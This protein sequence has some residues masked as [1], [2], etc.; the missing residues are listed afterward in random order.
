MP[1]QQTKKRVITSKEFREFMESDQ[2]LSNPDAFYANILA[3]KR[4][5]NKLVRLSSKQE[6]NKL[7]DQADGLLEI[8]KES[9]NPVPNRLSPSNNNATRKVK[10][11]SLSNSSNDELLSILASPVQAPLKKPVAKAP[12]KVIPVPAKAPVKSVARTLKKRNSP[13]T[14]AA[15]NLVTPF[16]PPVVS[17]ASCSKLNQA[18]VDNWIAG[19]AGSLAVEIARYRRDPPRPTRKEII[20]P[21]FDRD[22]V[23]KQTEGDGT[24]LL[25]AFLTDMSP[26]YRSLPRTV[27]RMTGQA[28]RKQVYA[29][30]FPADVEM[31]L[32]QED[33]DNFAEPE[34]ST[35]ARE[36]VM[37][38]GNIEL[39]ANARAYIRD[40]DGY[41]YDTDVAHLQECFGVRILLITKSE[42]K[43][44]RIRL[45][46]DVN[47]ADL[48]REYA[49]EQSANIPADK[50]TKYILIF[51][52]PGHYEG[53][54]HRTR[55]QYIFG[56]PE[57][58]DVI[59]AAV[60]QEAAVDMDLKE[61][62]AP[63]TIVTLVDGRVATVHE[64]GVRG[65]FPPFEGA[66]YVPISVNLDV[67]ETAPYLADL[68]EIVSIGDMPFDSIPYVVQR[69]QPNVSVRLVN[70]AYRLVHRK[71]LQMVNHRPI[72]LWLKEG[73]G[74]QLYSLESI[75][76]V[77][78]EPAKGKVRAVQG[79]RFRIGQLKVM[80]SNSASSINSGSSNS[81]SSPFSSSS[82]SSSSSFS[83]SPSSSSSSSNSSSSSS[84]S[85]AS[86]LRRKRPVLTRRRLI[87]RP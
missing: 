6:I 59:E 4:Q 25:H 3:I 54:K 37:D 1:P 86:P 41:L 69:F 44:D 61:M 56:Y 57:V 53:I 26:A 24:C 43:H 65:W 51:V 63:D 74:S 11:V 52:R 66:S 5:R 64:D 79:E 68:T 39:R 30:L 16:E 76:F 55:D 32:E 29:F 80:N 62:L 35:R 18:F 45:I 2:W 82:S 28:F 15:Y 77:G 13:E 40:T 27:Q 20:A 31:K 73:A 50:Y 60:G 33:Y 8:L 49:G 17:P 78:S 84:N 70:G 58:R 72:G 7:L 83:S 22:F 71:G 47:P 19:K 46:G 81:S 85:S 23:I 34:P 87:R 38:D 48:A 36:A 42:V 75:A 14:L 9:G 12:A 10:K 67:G 21:A